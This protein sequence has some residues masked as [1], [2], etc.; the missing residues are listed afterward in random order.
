MENTL[1]RLEQHLINF[2][3]TKNPNDARKALECSCKVL[4]KNS[5]VADNEYEGKLAQGLIDLLTTERI[6]IS[7]TQLKKIKTELNL[8]NTYG[9]IDSHDGNEPLNDFDIEK[10]ENSISNLMDFIFNSEFIEIDQKIPVFIYSRYKNLKLENENWRGDKIIKSVYPNRDFKILIHNTAFQLF[11]VSEPDGRKLAFLFFGRNVGFTTTLEEIEKSIPIN[12]FISITILYPNE[13]SKITNKPVLNRANYI[14]N[15]SEKIFGKSEKLFIKCDFIE[16]YIWDQ[17]LP[18]TYKTISNITTEKYFIDQVLLDQNNN[19]IF[20]QELVKEITKNNKSNKSTPIYLIL[21]SGGAGKTTFCEQSIKAIDRLTEKGV[22]K[23]AILLSSYDLP[24]NIPDNKKVETIHDLFYLIKSDQDIINN[25]SLELN[26]SSGNFLIIVDGLDEIISKLKGKFDLESFINSIIA[27]NDTYLNCNIIIASRDLSSFIHSD[28]LDNVFK[29]ELQGFDNHLSTEY[30]KKRF[31]TKDNS[32]E[33]VRKGINYLEKIGI[34][35]N[36]TPLI[37]A[38]IGDLLLDGDDSIID[39]ESRYFIK[40]HPL[41]LII[42]QMIQRDIEKQKL[43]ISIENYFSIIRDILIEYNGKV[44]KNQLMYIIDMSIETQEKPYEAFLV[45]PLL[46]NRGEY[47]YLKYDALDAWFKTRILID[48]LS[49]TDAYNK[50]YLNILYTSNS[51]LGGDI[52]NEICSYNIDINIMNK[53]IKRIIYDFVSEG[54]NDN[55]RKILSSLLYIYVKKN[56]FSD[57]ESLS[58]GLK[59]ILIESTGKYIGLNIYGDF[60]SLDFRNFHIKD[61]YFMSYKNL[62][63]STFETPHIKTFFSSSFFKLDHNDF[64]KDLLSKD[65]FS[66]D[67]VLDDSVNKIFEND[68][69][70]MENKLENIKYDLNKIFKCGY[71]EGAFRW[72]SILVYKQ[73]CY[74]LKTSWKLE[75]WFNF[76]EEKG[77]LIKEQSKGSSEYGYIVNST[78]SQDIKN[79][80]TQKRLSP[81]LKSVITEI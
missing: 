12:S 29:L 19:N 74:S 45:S 66:T 71:K 15:L 43:N 64:S 30:F 25:Y 24:E 72:K 39:G 62:S 28:I 56:N 21:G 1:N 7:K 33:L 34:N 47:Y 58:L 81:I 9:S 60:F 49:N 26:I 17:C 32:I 36:P 59:E 16:N 61:G 78:Y 40:D 75:K 46:A 11:E 67:C 54:L 8:I 76:L 35:V 51:Y 14:K 80:L 69:K 65:L 41:D 55:D 18:N 4:L 68:A 27:L 37:L 20:S 5:G 2:E 50:D 53:N 13:I 42:Y 23:K 10:L 79:F 3:N 48:L 77:L 38:L 52:A 57:K 31:K 22:K 63:N 73:Q 44:T 6:N 70:K